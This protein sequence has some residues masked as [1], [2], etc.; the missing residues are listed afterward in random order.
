[1]QITGDAADGEPVGIDINGRRHAGIHLWT[2]Q[3]TGVSQDVRDQGQNGERG[4]KEDAEGDHDFD[5]REGGGRERGTWSVAR[6]RLHL[7]LV[8]S[9]LGSSSTEANPVVTSREMTRLGA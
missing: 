7:R 4:H 3:T 8:I 9:V 1:M 5:K 2:L 6:D